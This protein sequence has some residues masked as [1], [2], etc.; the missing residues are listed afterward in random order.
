MQVDVPSSAAVL[1]DATW[2]AHRYDPTHDAFH[3]R[4]VPR[5]A[6]TA[7][8]F[9]TDDC[10]GVAE[11]VPVISRL[12][13]ATA[14]PP[15]R[16]H[17]IFHSAFCAS[18]MLVHAFDRPGVAAGLSEPVIL[19]DLVGWRRRGADAR[20]HGR[21][22]HDALAQLARP[23]A[24]G[25]AVIVKPSNVINPLAAGM[26]TLR[27]DAK[28]LL[29]HAP[30]PAFLASVARKGL[31]CRLWVRELLEG[32][33]ADGALDL[34]F[35][36]RDYFRQSDLQV[37]AVGWVA[38]HAIFHALAARF[39]NTRIRTLDSERLVGDPET[40]TAAVARHFGLPRISGG[41]PAFGTD[42]KTGH[43]FPI[44]QRDREQTAARAAHEEE[45]SKVVDWTHAVAAQA[46]IPLDLPSPV[47]P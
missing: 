25:E 1:G 33:L 17:F 14:T 43:A 45:I 30:L 13:A 12:D 47:Q 27:P 22:T 38:Q 32:Y 21:V 40:V 39:G 10:L 6:R 35:G 37:A 15:G 29:L 19:N 18:T 20:Q 42:S 46:G 9:L 8:P 2:L 16:I 5:S 23:F 36:P 24:K 11:P 44:G 4:L 31:W 41:H 28:A 34:G 3:Y 26:L 7:V